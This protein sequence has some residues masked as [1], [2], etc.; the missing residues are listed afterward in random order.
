MIT[1]VFFNLEYPVDYT[2]KVHVIQILLSLARK[3]TREGVDYYEYRTRD[4]LYFV[5]TKWETKSKFTFS[6]TL[7]CAHVVTRE[8]ICDVKYLVSNTTIINSDSNVIV[9]NSVEEF[10]QMMIED[11][12]SERPARLN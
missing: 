5:S 3:L 7:F 11:A 8:G 10:K 6:G 1:E 12:L 9:V 2:E 4:T